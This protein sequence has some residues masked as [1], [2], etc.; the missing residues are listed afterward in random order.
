MCYICKNIVDLRTGTYSAKQTIELSNY[1][2]KH[3]PRMFY[4]NF[5]C[6]DGF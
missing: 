4:N 3:S 5:F 6:P 2:I 1:Q